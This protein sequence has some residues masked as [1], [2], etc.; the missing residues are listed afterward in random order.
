MLAGSLSTSTVYRPFKSVV[1]ASFRNIETLQLFEQ[2]VAQIS[3][4]HRE[5]AQQMGAYVLRNPGTSGIAI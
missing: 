5:S 2:A 1:G 4:D 3:A